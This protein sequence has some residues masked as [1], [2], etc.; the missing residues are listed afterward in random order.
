MISVTPEQR[1]ALRTRHKRV[2]LCKFKLSETYFYI[3]NE[4]LPIVFEGNTYAP[5][6]LKDVGEIELTGIPKTDDTNI[7]IDGTDSIFFGLIQ[8]QEWMNQPLIITSLI[9]DLNNA[10]IMS[11]IA[12]DGLISEIDIDDKNE[13]ELTLKVSSIWKDFEKT[14][15]IKTNYQSQ[16]RHYP[17][18]TAF[19]H[20]A[21]AT[22]AIAWGKDSKSATSSTKNTSN[23][24]EI[25]N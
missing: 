19:Q 3:S 1:A 7:T 20:S 8:S 10:L 16:S 18:D 11:R 15:G 25:Q 21:R 23:F 2:L 14:A 6:Y 12:Y 9:Y 24:N 22:K 5:G 13:Y 4:D 17:G